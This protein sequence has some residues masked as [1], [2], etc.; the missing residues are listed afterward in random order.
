MSTSLEI[1]LKKISKYPLLAKEEEQELS[2]KAKKGDKSAEQKLVTSNLRLVVSIAKKYQYAIDILDAINQ[3]NI[4]LIQAVQGFDETKNL[5]FGT[6]ASWW[7]NRAIT[8]FVYFHNDIIKQSSSFF[9]LQRHIK[10]FQSKT[11]MYPTI[12]QL[13]ELTNIDKKVIT[14]S[15]TYYQQTDLDAIVD[16]ESGNSFHEI[17]PDIQDTFSFDHE[18]IL[19]HSCLNPKEKNVIVLTFG[20][21]EGGYYRTL[22]EVSEILK[23]SHECVRQTKINALAKIRRAIIKHYNDIF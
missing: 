14:A 20:F 4:G 13:S 10:N 5:K 17:I 8:N 15:L 23:V 18:F 12:E 22:K 21:D 11:Q 1:Y 9:K 3:G 7:I 6:Y 16:E 19:S 2:I